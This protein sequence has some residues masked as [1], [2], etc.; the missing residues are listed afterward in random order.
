[1]WVIALMF[2]IVF[3]DRITKV[4]AF[5][6]LK[7]Q[8]PVVLILRLLE[9]RYAE[10]TGAAWSM[11]SGYQW[12][13]IA[14]SLVMLSILVFF[15]KT[16]WRCG[17]WGKLAFGLLV[18]GIVGNLADRI[19]YRYV[20][21]F[22]QVYIGSYPFPIFNIADMAICL[23]GAAYVITSLRG[24][25]SSPSSGEGVPEGWGSGQNNERGTSKG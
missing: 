10:N 23:G 6:F 19:L 16:L 9:F 18:S 7:H 1:M 3:V 21:D 5:H 11:L 17:F 22:I 4:A 8:D 12:I 15:A 14:I 25:K 20:I 2:S 13:L 24:E